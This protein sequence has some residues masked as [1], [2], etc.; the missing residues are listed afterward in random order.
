MIDE[1][2]CRIKLL[3]LQ[4]AVFK[5][6]IQNTMARDRQHGPVIEV[7]RL[8]V[9]KCLKFVDDVRLVC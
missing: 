2:N 6:V 7:N 8:Q 1:L 4:E 5:K 3:S 9:C